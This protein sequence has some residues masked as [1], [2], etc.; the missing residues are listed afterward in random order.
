MEL[1]KIKSDEFDDIYQQMEASFIRDEIRDYGDALAL[2][3]E[4]C[5]TLF[6]IVENGT[7]VGFISVWVFD[8]FAFAEH[9]VICAEYRN[10]GYGGRAIRLVAERFGTVVLEA[11]TPETELAARRIA[12]YERNGF[13]CNRVPYMQPPYRKDSAPV[14]LVLMSTPKL[15]PDPDAVIATLYRYVYKKK[16]IRGDLA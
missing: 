2:L 15:L 6:H 16:Y 7:H 4:P 14:R 11:E 9:F 10:C 12:F 1:I 3:E 5:Y 8:G 13:V